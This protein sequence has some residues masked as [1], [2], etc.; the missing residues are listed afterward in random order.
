MEPALPRPG[1]NLRKSRF[2]MIFL[3]QAGIPAE[4]SDAAQSLLP[5]L[6]AARDSGRTLRD[7][8]REASGMDE[9]ALN[10]ATRDNPDGTAC[11]EFPRISDTG[12]RSW[13]RLY[14]ER[15]EDGGYFC[16]IEDVTTQK[17]RESALVADKE[18][19]ERA[20]VTR[21]QFLANISHE[22]R[23][24]IQTITG[25]M[26][27]LGDTSL[28]E[29]QTEY[30]RQVRFSADVMLTLVND[31]LD[32]SKAEAGQ[33]KI[34]R[35]EFALPDVIERTIDLVSMEAHRKGLEVCIDVDPDLPDAVLGDPG[36]FRQILLNL[37]KNAV[38]FTERG[39]ILV[40]AT[41]ASS[42]IADGARLEVRDTGIGIKPG[43]SD[44]LF[45]Q[46][47][48]ADT[49][50]TRKYGGT[51]LGLAIS[52]NLVE[53]MSG[54]IGQLP[55]EPQGSV[56]WFEVPLPPAPKARTIGETA[57]PPDSADMERHRDTRFLLVDD[58]DTAS[59]GL[60]RM[61]ASMGYRS[62]ER[63]ESG[64]A[65]LEALATASR[66]GRPYEIV[67]IDMIMPGMDG[68]RLAAEINANR[69]I[70]QAQ[71]YLMVPEGGFGADAKMKL[72]EWF[73]GYLYKPIKRRMLAE[74][75]AEHW[76]ASIDLEVVEELDTLEPAMDS[77]DETVAPSEPNDPRQMSNV[78]ASEPLPA[79]ADITAEPS[80]VAEPVDSAKA[81]ASDLDECAKGMTILIVEDHPVNRRLLKIFLEKAGARVIEAGDGQE[82]TEQFGKAKIDL[83]FMDIQMPVMNGYE[84]AMWIRNNGYAQPIV[85]CTASADENERERCLACGMTDVL[86]KPYKRQDVLELV[87]NLGQSLGQ[88]EQAIDQ[89]TAIFDPDALVDLLMGDLD[90]ARLLVT[91]YCEQ[92]AEHIRF[93]E[94]DIARGDREAIR[95]TAHLIKGSSLNITARE[96][97]ETARV[98]ELDAENGT[99]SVHHAVYARLVKNFEQLREAFKR[100]G[101]Q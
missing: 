91:E 40:R 88:T 75:L 101:Y 32:I 63:V 67:F 1:K 82:A 52:R 61:L 43:V 60:I 66:A 11:L 15:N 18:Q 50:T 33:L 30:V 25:M 65:A 7:Y 85:A 21:I 74:L 99:E 95:Q 42:E 2:P 70:N 8:I 28:D 10:S 57:V 64:E 55:N 83:V 9:S 93:L 46:F 27:L 100:E 69:E 97:A 68:W 76:Q 29:E 56:F 54:A 62:T 6:S 77:A 58:N 59:D 3:D 12:N 80:G 92:T 36:R 47:F 79:G 22:I 34:E 39:E 17:I 86:P 87:K 72:L 23:T 45:T 35:I 37:V 13:Q 16:I 24:P 94:E 4:W 53:L 84:S 89:A 51:G 41:K 81:G 49:S 71:L 44:K 98:L 96:L 78:P 14:S 48:Q 19:A 73:N 20:S 31:I 26:E 5:G 38:K 90:S